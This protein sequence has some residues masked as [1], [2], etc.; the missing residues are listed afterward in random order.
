[1]GTLHMRTNKDGES[2]YLH[3]HLSE[4]QKW[5]MSSTSIIIRV[6]DATTIVLASSI[7]LPEPTFTTTQ[8]QM[9]VDSRISNPLVMDLQPVGMAN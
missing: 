3:I 7:R 4:V 8:L 9:V 1:M 6:D 5:H 2:N